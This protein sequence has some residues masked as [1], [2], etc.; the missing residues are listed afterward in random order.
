MSMERLNKASD[1]SQDP[2]I[3]NE[4]QTVNV[5]VLKQRLINEDR[6]DNIKKTIM[7]SIFI[8]ILVVVGILVI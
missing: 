7:L 8:S 3:V 2:Y 6:K 1:I 5:D 4:K